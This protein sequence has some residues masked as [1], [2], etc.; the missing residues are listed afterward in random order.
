MDTGRVPLTGL[1]SGFAFFP[2]EKDEK[3]KTNSDG[4]NETEESSSLSCSH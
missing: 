4:N 2:Q 3:K 1:F